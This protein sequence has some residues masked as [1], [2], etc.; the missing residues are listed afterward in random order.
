VVE[1]KGMGF[2]LVGQDATL[3][4]VSSSWAG[5]RNPMGPPVFQYSGFVCLLSLCFKQDLL[6]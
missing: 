2:Y 5:C 3:V 4:R 1:G 6:N